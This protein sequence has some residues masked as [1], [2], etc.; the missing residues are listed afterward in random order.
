[1]KVLISSYPMVV[2]K[3]VVKDPSEKRNRMQLLPT[4]AN[5]NN[6]ATIFN[7]STNWYMQHVHRGS[8]MPPF[9]A[10]NFYDS[11]VLVEV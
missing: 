3:L 4:P 1:M 2:M 9:T 6:R 8:Q 10:N 7:D 5:T 11:R